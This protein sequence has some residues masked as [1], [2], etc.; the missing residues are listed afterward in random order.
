MPTTPHLYPSGDVHFTDDRLIAGV[1]F[2]HITDLHLQPVNEKDRPAEY[3]HGIEWWEKDFAYPLKILPGLLDE[4]RD[5]GVDFVFFG[6]DTLDVYDAATADYVVQLCSQRGLECHFQMGNHDMEDMHTRY[7]THACDAQARASGV[8]RLKEHWDMPHRYYSFDRGGVRFIALDVQ[9]GPTG[10]GNAGYFDDEQV[11]WLPAQLDFPGPIV[12][13]H[14]VPFNLPTLTERMRLIWHGGEAWIA[15]DPNTRAVIDSLTACPNVFATFT[16]H[17]HMR[18]EDRLSEHCHQFMTGPG[19]YGHWRRIIIS[20]L[21]APK[22]LRI[23]G[24][25]VIDM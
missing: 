19:G 7:V 12:I 18:S 6:G 20:P 13:F 8:A 3:R 15:E 4:V 9:Y 17:T 14:H 21:P 23:G 2:A 10:S 22:S 1:R 16:G 5:A 11:Q 24:T 25:P